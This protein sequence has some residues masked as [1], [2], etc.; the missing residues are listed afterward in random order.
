M[1]YILNKTMKVKDAFMLRNVNPN[2]LMD[3]NER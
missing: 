3:F 1:K 2:I